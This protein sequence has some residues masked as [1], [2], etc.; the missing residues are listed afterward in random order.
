MKSFRFSSGWTAR[1]LTVMYITFLFAAA[2]VK[3]FA[4]SDDN[5]AEATAVAQAWMAQID[6]GHYEEVYAAGCIAFHE[7]VSLDKW[8]SVLKTIRIPLGTVTSRKEITHLNKPDGFEGLDGQ[9]IVFKYA[10]SFSKLPEALEVVVVKREDGHWKGA[11][12]NL[13]PKQAAESKAVPTVQ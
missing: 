3:N 6:A 2:S 8:V 7:K 13:M 11:G 5:A 10:T 9:C 12:Y 1:L 4:A